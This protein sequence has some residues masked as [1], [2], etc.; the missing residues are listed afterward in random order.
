MFCFSLLNL[1]T[2]PLRF[3]SP[4]IDSVSDRHLFTKH[5]R[6]NIS[7]DV[8]VSPL[9]YSNPFILAIR[10]YLHPRGHSGHVR[11]QVPPRL[12]PYLWHSL[13]PYVVIKVL[14]TLMPT[15]GSSPV[16]SCSTIKSTTFS[17]ALNT[18]FAVRISSLFLSFLPS[19]SSDDE[20][21]GS[22]KSGM[23]WCVCCG[24][25]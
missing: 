16:N 14:I 10:T 4:R 17:T 12:Q 18:F 25:L 7:P 22:C 13:P 8:C 20:I 3:A 23:V 11:P 1:P 2:I 24:V 19:P 15:F 6:V 5:P 9:S 21:W